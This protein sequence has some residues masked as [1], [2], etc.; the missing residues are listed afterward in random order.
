VVIAVCERNQFAKRDDSDQ[1]I[2]RAREFANYDAG[3]MIN[4]KGCVGSGCQSAIKI[5]Y[6]TTTTTLGAGASEYTSTIKAIHT[7]SGT[8]EIGVEGISTQD[9]TTPTE[10]TTTDSHASTTAAMI[11]SIPTLDAST[12][13]TLSSAIS[14]PS[15]ATSSQIFS[16]AIST[17]SI[18]GSS[19]FFS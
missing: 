10:Q 11:S 18:A 6:V 3:L 16:S 13:A 7:T 15:T 9:T 2:N 17:E 8:I 4:A 5:N 19:Q 12:S 1:S 14:S